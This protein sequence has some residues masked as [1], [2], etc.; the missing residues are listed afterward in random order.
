VAV[1]LLLFWVLKRLLKDAARAS[2]LLSLGLV[3]FYSYGHVYN[4][5]EQAQPLGL[6][7]GRHRYLAPLWLLLLAV[8]AWWILRSVKNPAA[9]TRVLTT[10][11][12]VLLLLP[13]VQITSASVTSYFARQSLPEVAPAGRLTPEDPEHLPDIYLIILD[14]YA[15]HDVLQASYAFDNRPFL[16]ELERLG[17]FVAECSQSNYDHTETSLASELNYDFIENLVKVAPQ[18]P[19][20]SLLWPLIKQSAVRQQLAELGYQLVAFETGYPWSEIKDADVYLRPLHGSSI[21][22]QMRPFEAMLIKTTALSLLADSQALLAQ[23]AAWDADYLHYNRQL[24]LLSELEQLPKMTPPKFVY[25]HV[26]VP[27]EPFVFKADGGLQTDSA[28]YSEGWGLP[29]DDQHDQ[30]GYRNQ[31]TFINRRLIPILETILRESQTPPIIL[32]QSDH[33]VAPNRNANLGA[34]YL[35]GDGKDALY[36]QITSVNT[37][38]VVFNAYFDGQYPLLPDRAYESSS[39]GLL[40]DLTI[41]DEA[42]PACP[43]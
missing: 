16:A 7:L 21:L 11:A 18:N 12:I 6:M 14:K 41:K 36:S 43:P 39:Q 5:L 1:A 32:L 3:L 38:R 9:V 8:G 30:E 40:Y 19:D 27:H 20:H 4:Y 35:P 13:L 23:T 42:P 22:A 17:F 29:I 26:L 31:V 33:G 34:Y 15:R 24:F 10:S 25:A 2:L 28:F 37:F